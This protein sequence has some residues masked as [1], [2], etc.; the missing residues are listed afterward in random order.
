[1]F[2]TRSLLRK[3]TTMKKMVA[4]SQKSFS[5]YDSIIQMDDLQKSMKEMARDFSKAEIEPYAEQIDREDAHDPTIWKKLGEYGLLGITAPEEYGGVGLG[6]FEHCLVSE[7]ISRASASIG[8]SYIAHSNLCI[9]Q[10]KLNGNDIQKEKYLPKLI[11]GEYVGA[12]AM[13]EA[14]SGSDVTSMKTTAKKE[15]DKYIL[16]GTKMWITNGPTADVVFVYAKTDTDSKHH[17]ISAFIVETDTPGF[18]VAQKLDKFGMRGSGTGEL[19][20]D[21][22]EVPAENLVKGEGQGVYIL[23]SGLDFERLLLASGPVGI[24]QKC[25]DITMPYVVDRKQFGKS[26]GEFQ[27]MQAKMANMYTDLQSTR[28]FMYS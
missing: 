3:S 15:G 12:L 4:V 20:F 17:G 7:E 23:M 8:L 25:M 5:S 18:S 26:I 14:G 9:N 11:S 27:I 19:V 28:A 6:Y 13:S 24:M 2:L 10:I 1:M 21:N 16:N 22:V